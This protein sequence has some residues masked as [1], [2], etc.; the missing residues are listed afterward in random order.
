M[1]ASTRPSPH[2]VVAKVACHDRS[3]RHLSIVIAKVAC[4]DRNSRHVSIVIAK[5]A[6]HDG[7]NR[8]AIFPSRNGAVAILVNSARPSS[9]QHSFEQQ[10]IR[11][12]SGNTC[13]QNLDV[14]RRRNSQAPFASPPTIFPAFARERPQQCKIA[15]L[16]DS[17]RSISRVHG[18]K[19]TEWHVHP[20]ALGAIFAMPSASPGRCYADPLLSERIIC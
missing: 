15:R 3:N 1:T 16:L 2:L 4:H 8:G 5:V 7:N 20:Q 18:N 6:C 17:D 13:R 11:R 9:P 10:K 14:A 12:R 19:R